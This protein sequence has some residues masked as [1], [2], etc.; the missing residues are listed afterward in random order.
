[1]LVT[2]N[3]LTRSLVYLGGYVLP[4]RLLE[5]TFPAF[6]NGLPAAVTR[7]DEVNHALSP[8]VILRCRGDL[9]GRRAHGRGPFASPSRRGCPSKAAN[10]FGY[11][12][13]S[14]DGEDCGAHEGSAPLSGRPFDRALAATRREPP[15]LPVSRSRRGAS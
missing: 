9:V 5:L 13:E 8:L 10:R 15:G 12:R 2:G 4:V 3:P 6:D 7:A 14:D 1:M 11:E